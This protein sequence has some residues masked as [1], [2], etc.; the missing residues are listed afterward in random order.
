MFSEQLLLQYDGATLKHYILE[1]ESSKHSSSVFFLSPNLIAKQL[2]P[3]EETDM[4]EAMQCAGLLGVRVPSIKR[5]VESSD[6]VYIIM[7]RIYGQ[8]LEDAW[9]H[10]SWFTILRLAF[11][12]RMFIRR[13]RTVSATTAGS[14]STGVCRSIWL[15]DY[16]GLPP[17]SGPDA[18]TAFIQF[19]LNFIPR[20]QRN[21]GKQHNKTF[22]PQNPARLVFTHQDLAPRNMILDEKCRIWVL[23]W[24][25]SGWY[26]T[27]FEYASMQNFHTPLTWGWTDKL[28]WKVFVWISVGLFPKEHEALDQ[29]RMRFTRYP[30]GRK[31]EVLREGAPAHAVHLRKPGM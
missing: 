20:S 19:W 25:Y 7:E 30:L 28:F 3:G 2:L 4:L 31:N 21:T 9:A 24:D 15:D 16:Y 27:Y 6:N 23:D 10:L 14:L 17:H 1:S 22:C 18:I 5:V 8:T 12:L 29:A 11:Q 13:M 26:P